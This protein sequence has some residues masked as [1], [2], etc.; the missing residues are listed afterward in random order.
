MAAPRSVRFDEDVLSRLD[1]YVR[2]HPGSSSSSV[3]NMFI[4]EAL[5]SHE[6]PGVIFRPGPTGRRAA[7]SGGPD[8]WE[9]IGAL[10]DIRDEN[11][12]ADPA[13]LLAELAEVTGLTATIAGIAVRYYAAYPGEI[14]ERIVLN[15]ET[16]D[17]EERLWEAQQ[18]ILRKPHS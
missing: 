9:V 2:E 13:S 15:R 5:R 6:H 10:K 16:A 8:V 4:D 3:A 7:L 11:P 1:R 12:E 18:A 17:R 14:D